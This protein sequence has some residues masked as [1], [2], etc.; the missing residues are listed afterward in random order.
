MKELKITG[1]N[2][3]KSLL[4]SKDGNCDEIINLR[5]K[6]GQ[7]Q[8]M[9]YK[10]VAYDLIDLRDLELYSQFYRHPVTP[11]DW[12]ISVKRNPATSSVELVKALD[13]TSTTLLGFT[14]GEDVKKI[15]HFGLF[16]I[17][18]T[19]KNV[20]FFKFNVESEEY[21]LMPPMDHG[22]YSVCSYK[23]G[24]TIQSRPER[25]A[26]AAV[27]YYPAANPEETHWKQ[28]MS[29]LRNSIDE[30]EKEGYCNG[31]TFFRVAFKMAD[32][33]VIMPT[34]P[35]YHFLGMQQ[36][37]GKAAD[38][39]D[40]Y[41][42]TPRL[43]DK[44]DTGVVNAWYGYF[45]KPRFYLNFTQEQ[46]DN[47]QL[48]DGVINKIVIYMTK[49]LK[50]RDVNI[51]EV[52]DLIYQGNNLP[53]YGNKYNYPYSDITDTVADL[54]LFYK[55]H[56]LNISE[57]VTS[58]NIIIDTGDLNTLETKSSLGVDNFT[59]HKIFSDV[60][61]EYNSKL[62][63]GCPTTRF[64]DGYNMSVKAL[65]DTGII[66]EPEQLE[67]LT[68]M[69]SPSY[70]GDGNTPPHEW[71]VYSITTLKVDSETKYVVKKHDDIAIFGDVKVNEYHMFLNQVVSYPDE[72]ATNIKYVQYVNGD[73]RLLGSIDLTRHEFLNLAYEQVE[74][75]TWNNQYAL[76]DGV[77]LRVFQYKSFNLVSTG[78]LIN[79]DIDNLHID[80]NRLQVSKLNNLFYYPAE[81]SY[82]IGK[83][84]NEILGISTQAV[85]MSE[86][87]F[88][89][90]P[91][92][93]FTS[94]GIYL[95]KQ[96]TGDVLY[97]S[98]HPLTHDIC[99][100][101]NSITQVLG[102][103]LFTSEKGLMVLTGRKVQEISK[104]M[105]G[106][107]DTY[108]NSDDN[109]NQSID[110]TL[111]V[112]NLNNAIS[113]TD[114]NTFLTGAIIAYDQVN[115]EILISNPSETDGVR[116]YQYTYVYSHNAN[117]WYKSSQHFKEFIENYPNGYALS[118]VKIYGITKERTDQEIG[119]LIRTRPFTLNDL[120]LKTIKRLVARYKGV[121]TKKTT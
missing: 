4:G 50:D 98:V 66:P 77:G 7:W 16:L 61:F 38:L 89:E 90:Y 96:G 12:F 24:E 33:T 67:L 81:N 26:G 119:I 120:N 15:Y 121:T 2:R 110:G 82:R 23:Q 63:I 34:T 113:K 9:P 27:S 19:N 59:A 94:N 114:F 3:S 93:L 39:E 20:Y 36:F 58:N 88:G 108:L 115:E 74:P 13:Q 70:V 87:Q 46:I 60:V 31:H 80:K 56:E 10:D 48:Y 95:L 71:D 21:I 11:E 117:T 76:H 101:K 35:Y 100:N 73:Y 111:N 72:R 51:T 118:G 84:T 49:P 1:I 105:E 106:K 55:V 44:K 97:S 86:G 25:Q 32:G 40:D 65:L 14:D 68:T 116:N 109:Y 28:A 92:T 22:L 102:G 103:I 107:P 112:V 79:V 52:N 53:D 57:L 30:I 8:L 45:C 18:N 54:N 42:A 64:N 41:M 104:V 75:Y 83:L 85:P 47:L 91:I 43:T 78:D 62:H 6:N 99:N 37:S 5:N 17:I 69:D 29:D